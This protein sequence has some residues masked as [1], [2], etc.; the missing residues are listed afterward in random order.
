MTNEV[1]DTAI[2]LIPKIAHPEQLSDFRTISLCK[3]LYKIVSKCLVN[4]LRPFLQDL[5]SPHQC[6]LV[7]E[8]LIVFECLLAIQNTTSART[9]FSAQIGCI[10]G[11]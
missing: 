9:N 11:V 2:V 6:V 10:Q 7:P 5:I 1:N 3:A 8:Q 4:C